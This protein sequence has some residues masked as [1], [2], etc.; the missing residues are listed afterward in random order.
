MHARTITRRRSIALLTIALMAGTATHALAQVVPAPYVEPGKPGD[1][2]SWAGTT[3]FKNQWGLG[4]INAQYAYALGY[5]GKGVGLGVFDTGTSNFLH[6]FDGRFVAV[7][8]KGTLNVAMDAAG[9]PW[10]IPNPPIHAGD[11]Y[12]LMGDRTIVGDQHG[13][14]VGGVIAAARNGV[15]SNAH[16]MQGV[17]FGATLVAANGL[18][19]GPNNGS[20]EAIDA[21]LFG[22]ALDGFVAN[23]VR[24]MN[25]SWEILPNAWVNDSSGKVKTSATGPLTDVIDQYNTDTSKKVFDVMHSAAHD[26]QMLFVAAAGN[27]GSVLVPT[28]FASLPY[29]Q[30]DMA[31]YMIAVVN[32]GSAK[33]NNGT[34]FPGNP[35]YVFALSSTPCAQTRQWCVAAPG[36][37]IVSTGFDIGDY[38]SASARTIE[39]ALAVTD[40]ATLT[41]NQKNL[42]S[43][44]PGS[45]F[46]DV[47]KTWFYPSY[48]TT[49]GTSVAAPFVTGEAGIAFQRFPW[50]TTPQITEAIL[51]HHAI[52][53][54][55]PRAPT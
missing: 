14:E 40:P 28:A 48:K 7:E 15:D 8:S 47:N 32:V 11:A 20:I 38:N 18:Y 3:E 17:A 6:E 13:T 37:S 45:V 35:D 33:L 50:M 31:G 36:S 54:T 39:Q 26:H 34:K 44:Y 16:G 52:C 4:V 10:N 1:P 29:F 9:V 19:V 41:T 49:N 25:N 46:D 53:R 2:A 22:A 51:R 21:G 27:G 5:T 55:A 23:N 42:I 43:I 24:V 30:P 12:D